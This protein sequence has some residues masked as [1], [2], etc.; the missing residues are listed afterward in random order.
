[1]MCRI[2]GVVRFSLVVRKNGRHHNLMSATLVQ[3][4][5]SRN[6]HGDDEE[7]DEEECLEYPYSR[8]V[9]SPQELGLGRPKYHNITPPR[10]DTPD[11][12]AT[13]V[14]VSL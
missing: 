5:D 3:L 14:A 10:T 1:M 11:L 2:L 7:E 4:T 6:L 12:G 8:L 13:N 9:G